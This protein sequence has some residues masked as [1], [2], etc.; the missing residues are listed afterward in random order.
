[1]P[2]DEPG[3]AEAVSGQIIELSDQVIGLLVGRQFSVNFSMASYYSSEDNGATWIRR[4]VP[5]NGAMSVD[6]DGLLWLAGGTSSNRLY[7]SKDRGATW[8]ALVLPKNLTGD[9][10]AL[11]PPVFLGKETF[12]Y[13]QQC[14]M[15]I[16]PG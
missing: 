2:P 3:M 13:L 5:V 7:L 14:R 6:T 10:V 11:R 12:V 4:E 16:Q 9:N 8:K 15:A 1:M